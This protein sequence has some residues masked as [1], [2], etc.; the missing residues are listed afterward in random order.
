MKLVTFNCKNILTSKIVLDE[1]YDKVKA[2]VLLIQEHWLFDCYLHKLNEICDS[3]T[4]IGK[5][6]DTNNPIL[7]V[8]IPR[9]YGGTA[10]L[11][12]REIDHLIKSLPDG[13]NRIQCVELKGQECLLI[14]SIYMPCK[15][16][17]DNIEDFMDCV[18]Q[19]NEIV[20]KYRATHKIIIGGDINEDI[21][22]GTLGR[23]GQYFVDFVKNNC[24]NIK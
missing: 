13:G 2:D 12:K 21:S 20:T 14:I 22:L 5:A 19:L 9:G 6:V 11:W 10:V 15:G 24:L 8:Q 17:S 4:G 16:L 1:F 18:D 7:P 3:Y 23:R